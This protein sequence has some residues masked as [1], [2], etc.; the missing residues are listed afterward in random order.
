MAINNWNKKGS[1][2]NVKIKNDQEGI[3]LG[4]Q[5]ETQMTTDMFHLS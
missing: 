3:F 5:N 2:V 1:H 4:I